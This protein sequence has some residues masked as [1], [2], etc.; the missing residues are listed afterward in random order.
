M[1]TSSL[2]EHPA[3]E[4]QESMNDKA[5]GIDMAGLGRKLRADT[6]VALD[7]LVEKV[8][9]GTFTRKDGTPVDVKVEGDRISFA[10]VELGRLMVSHLQI[11]CEIGMT[12][13][14]AALD[15]AGIETEVRAAEDEAQ[16]P[17]VH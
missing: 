8:K 3:P 4:R 10:K 2:V 14:V 13:M 17:T 9:A 6:Q 7:A 16:K 11:G 5:I 15:K 1:Y 12:L